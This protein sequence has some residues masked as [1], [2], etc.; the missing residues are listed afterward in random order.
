MRILIAYYSKTGKTETIS[1]A[2]KE[3]LEPNCEVEMLKIKMAK[4]Y[5]GLL[6]HLNP[7]I[8]FDIFLSRKPEIKTAIDM[9]PY[10]LVCV[11]T[12][13]WYGR[14]APP[15]NT[16]IEKV[17]G[18]KGKKAVAFVSSGFGKES[19]ADGLANRLEEKGFKVL[20][21]LS[22]SIREISESQ[23]I[24]IGERIGRGIFPLDRRKE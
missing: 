21:K 4:E 19:Y 3:F 20:K 17:T 8:L 5:S 14:I 15:V 6:P 9:S 7:R 1:K 18:V 2:I 11:G 24:E 13:N 23:L 12:P 10:D 22:L 16:F